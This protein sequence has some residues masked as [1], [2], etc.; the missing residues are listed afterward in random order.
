MPITV[1][2]LERL[3]C[4]SWRGNVRE[5]RNAVLDAARSA[6]AEG[7]ERIEVAH[8][9]APP[10]PSGETA[11]TAVDDPRRE[12][13]ERALREASG[14]VTEA[15]ERLGMRR[16]TVYELMKRFGIDPRAHR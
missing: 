9:E 14:N 6:R 16:A 1:D 2:A 12:Q 8:L 10:R 5:L 4:A 7:T 11:R 13:I 15:A 3:V